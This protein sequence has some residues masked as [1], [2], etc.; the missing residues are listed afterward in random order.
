MAD[1]E[2]MIKTCAVKP[3]V[4]KVLLRHH[5]TGFSKR[6]GEVELSLREEMAQERLGTCPRSHNTAGKEQS[7]GLNPGYLDSRSNALCSIPMAIKTN[8]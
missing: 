8:F 6:R 5:F 4:P 2:L 7:R 3:S 1:S